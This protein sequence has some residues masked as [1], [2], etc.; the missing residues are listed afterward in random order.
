VTNPLE[1]ELPTFVTVR[2]YVK[3]CPGMTGTEAGTWLFPIVRSLA[4]VGGGSMAT[5]S[6]S[7]DP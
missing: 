2:E 6:V 5:P 1:A 7:T 3:V 4:P